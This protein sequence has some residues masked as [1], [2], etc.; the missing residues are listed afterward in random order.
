M[1]AISL[2]SLV[3]PRLPVFL[4]NVACTL[5]GWRQRRQRHGGMFPERLEWLRQSE[6]WSETEIRAYQSNQLQAL[7]THAYSTVPYYR[8]LLDDAG[9]SPESIR[10][11][12]D[13]QRLPILTKETVRHRSEE[14]LSQAYSKARLEAA[15]T[16]GSTGKALDFYVE[17]ALVQ[18]R[19]A[20]WWR[21]RNRFGIPFGGP[22]AVFTGKPAVPMGRKKPPYWRENYAMRQTIFSMQHVTPAKAGAIVARLNQGNYDY[23]SG[24]PSI[25]FSLAQMIEGDRLR[26]TRPPKIIFTGAEKLH[27]FQ[28]QTLERVYRCHVTDQYGFA[29]GCGNASRCEHDR[30]HEDFE[31]GILEAHEPESL[32]G[33]LTR[34]KILAT[35]FASKA[36]PFIRYEVGDVGIWSN[37]RCPCGRHSRV[38]VDIEGRDEDFVRTPEGARI[39]RFD[40]LFKASA[41]VAEAQVVQVALDR[42]VIR[43]V[44][45]AGFGAEDEQALRHE[46]AKMISPSLRVDIKPMAEIPRTA[47]GKFRAVI[48]EL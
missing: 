15:H 24:Y 35:G 43:V 48:S 3:Y 29:E 31:F 34:G 33:G 16:S 4:Q 21:H 39:Q 19:W 25:L 17:P 38:L 5:Q 45:R 13:L 2:P 26:I 14:L 1:S 32:P 9:V 36:F 7:V 47:S 41:R 20:V 8:R 30:F 40:Y 42:I 6:W 28:R 22:F 44:P 12:E 27:P 37:E 23:Y 18:F 46:V 11:R 10:E